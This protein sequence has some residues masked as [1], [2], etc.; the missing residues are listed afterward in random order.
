MQVLAYGVR[1][2]S[3]R[4]GTKLCRDADVETG[5]PGPVRRPGRLR[6]LLRGV[7]AGCLLLAG[8][9]GGPPAAAP[10]ASPVTFASQTAIVSS[11]TESLSPDE[12]REVADQTV[13]GPYRLGPTD[14]ISVQVYLHPELDVPP[15][16]GNNNVGGA[17]ITS[18]GTT[19]L[20]LLG[21][22]T[23]GGMT[24][25]QAQQT[26]TQAYSKYIVDPKVAVQISSPNSLRYYLLGAFTTPGVK[27]PVH[28]L[29]L[30]EALALGGSV[31]IASADLK[32]A[33]V[34]QG[35]VKLPVDL[36]ALLVE[37][38]LSQNIPLASGDAVVIPA[39]TN[40]EAFVFGSVTKPGPVPFASGGL[41]LLQAM[42]AAGLDLTSL[43]NGEMS[44]IHIIR[45]NGRTAQFLVV[46]AAKIYNGQAASFTLEPGDIVFVPPTGVATW[47]QVLD[48]LLPALQVISDVL[49]PFVSI[50][51]L[52]QRN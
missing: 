46:D 17:L 2:E 25:S 43:T 7:V 1:N 24:I 37:G 27:F 38:D 12:M 39:A 10:S 35:S 9:G 48:Q 16:T 30:L 34:A 36:Y 22:I 44:A 50:K 52:K 6:I 26:I 8:C 13:D 11:F 31:D 4:S 19:E 45:G 18:D 51:Y 23:L 32:Q 49:N 47:N 42:A 5:F 15:I 20:P 29:D 28:P 41:S 3:C 33:Y 14:V 21:E 40:E